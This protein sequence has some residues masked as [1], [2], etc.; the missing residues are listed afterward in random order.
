MP[1]GKM[2]ENDRCEAHQSISISTVY[3]LEKDVGR[4]T[5]TV[6]PNSSLY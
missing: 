6:V 3:T 2:L 1:G 5:L 4:R